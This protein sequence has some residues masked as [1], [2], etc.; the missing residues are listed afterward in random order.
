M[1]ASL[2]TCLGLDGGEPVDCLWAAQEGIVSSDYP[3]CLFTVSVIQAPK[4]EDDEVVIYFKADLLLYAPGS[5]PDWVVQT[6]EDETEEVSDDE[7][8]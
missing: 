7:S 5:E 4:A 8:S 2:K 1:I 6:S 3:I